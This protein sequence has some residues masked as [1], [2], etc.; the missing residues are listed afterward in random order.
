MLLARLE[1]LQRKHTDLHK[2]IEVLEA[3]RAPDEIVQKLKVEKLHVKDEI[4]SV[5]EKLKTN[6]R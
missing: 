1:S 2:R 6:E 5:M 4:Q 3:E